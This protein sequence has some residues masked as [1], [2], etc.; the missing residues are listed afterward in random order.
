MVSEVKLMN[1]VQVDDRGLPERYKWFVLIN[2]TLAFLLATMDGSIV[3]I[4]LPNIFRGIGLDP[5]APQNSFF[6]LWLILG[7][8]A[9]TA[10]LVVSFGRLGDMFGRVRMF[11][12]GF[13]IFTFFSL[14]LTITPMHGTAAAIWLVVMRIFQGVGAAF[15][16]ANTAAILTD[17]F[18]EHQRG[19]ALGINSIAGISGSFIG[20][21]IGGLLAPISWRLIFLV[22]VPIGIAGTLW[23]VFNL[24]EL[25]FVQDRK[26]DW[27]G[28]VTFATGL[29]ALMVGVTYG[30]QPYGGHTMGWTSPMVI[31]CFSLGFAL[32]IAFV[33][34]ERHSDD[35]MFHLALFR[36]RPFTGGSLASFLASTARG[37]LMFTLIIWLQGV[38]LPLHGF[39]FESTP[40]WAGLAMLPLTLG[41]L[42]SGPISG[43][44]SDRFGPRPFTVAG[45]LLSALAFLFLEMLPVNFSYP[46]FAAVLFLSAVGMGLFGSPNR[47]GVMNSLPHQHRGV[48]GGMYATFQNSGQVF[49]IGI[50]FTL[51]IIGISTSLHTELV[52][53]LLGQGVSSAD[54]NRVAHLPAVSTLFASLLGFNP[55]QHLLGAHAL[56]TLPPAAHATVVSRSYFPSIISGAFHNGLRTACNFSI[57]C[58]LLAAVAGVLRGGQ[59]IYQETY[60]D[61]GLVEDAPFPRDPGFD[62]EAFLSEDFE[63]SAAPD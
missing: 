2:T 40:L 46:W 3:L 41:F 47:A 18:P 25:P 54:A 43:Y 55:L 23:S 51:I 16:T 30:I 19:M 37:G 61:P 56:S 48:G 49:S 34:I 10:V 44:L 52:Q 12:F 4:A 36:I 27:W 21:V 22:T 28:N 17:A 39:G 63:P 60:E 38:W 53:G 58:C 29:I 26:I 14:L 32:L 8:L 50:F 5:L 42:V 45:M 59:F 24:R 15:L 33:L 1:R 9:V 57:I 11:N 6:L 7:F 20:L 13:A 62:A 31:G 35:P